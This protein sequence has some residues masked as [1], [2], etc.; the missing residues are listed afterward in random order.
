MNDQGAKALYWMKCLGDEF[1][2][3]ATSPLQA[4][5]KMMLL[6]VYVD[7]F[8]QVWCHFYSGTSKK[9]TQKQAFS[10]WC[11]TFLFNTSNEH[12]QRNKDEFYILDGHLL[13]KIRNS[14]LHFGGLPNLG[15]IPIFI[16]TD[17]REV[18]YEKYD[19]QLQGREALV[20]C[21]N[22]LF[23]AV[24]IAIKNTIEDLFFDSDDNPGK[25]DAI[26]MYL[27]ERIQTDSALP[28]TVR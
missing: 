19:Q 8:S 11:D 5:F 7:I 24:A 15:R 23:V 6:M 4:K 12:Y 13:Y 28:I 27:D 10:S 14:L 1:E 20:L 2:H 16:S 18:F 22:M 26:L 3:I 25:A 21:S 17:S 9:R